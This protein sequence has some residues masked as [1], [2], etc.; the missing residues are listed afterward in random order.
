MRKEKQI[1]KIRNTDPINDWMKDFEV[2]QTNE[3]Q[4]KIIRKIR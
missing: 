3:W 4:K 1:E 2:P